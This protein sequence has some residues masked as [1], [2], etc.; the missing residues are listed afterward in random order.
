MSRVEL[1]AGSR[2]ELLAERI[3]EAIG[4]LELLRSP[5]VAE[6]VDR[7]A[8]AVVGALRGGGRV[9]LCGNGGS[10]ADAQHLAA[11]LVGRF[12]LE[13]QP[14]AAIALGDNVAAVTAIGN[15]YSY[16]EVFSRAVLA[17]GRPGDVLIGLSTSGRSANVVRALEAGRSRG[18]V[19][20]AFVGAPGSPMAAAADLV[21]AV[22][23]PGTARIQ[24]AHKLLGHTIFE[25]AE[26]ELC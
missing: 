22:D 20:C 24:E 15:D 4:V 23:G 17:H 14:F 3:D 7:I 11:E 6:A 21:V 16:D 9:L 1:L 25:I 2:A 13:R 18:L 5:P 26:R 19:T 10:A 12:Q 8:G